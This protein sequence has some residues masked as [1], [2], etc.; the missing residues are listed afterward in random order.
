MH[1][2]S[3]SS[4]YQANFL[5]LFH[6]MHLSSFSYH[7]PVFSFFFLSCACLLFLFPTMRLPSLSFSYHA[8]F[9]F[10]AIMQI[11]SR[12]YHATFL[13]LFPTMHLSSLSVSQQANLSF[14]YHASSSLSSSYYATFTPFFFSIMTRNTKFW[15]QIFSSK[16]TSISMATHKT[17]PQACDYN[18]S[19]LTLVTDKKRRR[20]RRKKRKRA[21]S[22]G[23]CYSPPPPP[24]W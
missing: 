9:L 14:S 21:Q 10:F 7:V 13:F 4:S 6:V 18:L 22:A 5:S 16:A 24:A 8:T 12:S 23:A 19:S 20:R 17:L 1:L 15:F 11:N 3:L 2:S